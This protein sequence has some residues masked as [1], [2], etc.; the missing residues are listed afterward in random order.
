MALR[1]GPAR[2]VHYGSSR[3]QI[4]LAPFRPDWRKS[5]HGPAKTGA[6]RGTGCVA[7]SIGYVGPGEPR[8]PRLMIDG[9]SWSLF[10]GP[11]NRQPR[12]RHADAA[13]SRER[14]VAERTALI[15]QLRAILLERGI[16]IPSCNN[17]EAMARPKM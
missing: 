4:P 6:G 17:S 10:A 8:P 12:A 11:A 9:Q 7:S 5:A 15:D 1:N 2:A 14:L 16:V 3:R 13:C